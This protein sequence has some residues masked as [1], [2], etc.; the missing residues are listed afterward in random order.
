MENDKPAI[1]RIKELEEEV[2]KLRNENSRLQ[3][4]LKDHGIHYSLEDSNEDYDSEQGKRIHSYTVDSSMANRFFYMFWG[5]MDVYSQRIVNKKGKVGYYPQCW[6]FW[7]QGCSK[8]SENQNENKKKRGSVC[9]D[10]TLQ[11]WKKVDLGVLE[12]HLNGQI[13]MGIYP[14]LADNTCRLLVFDFDNHSEGSVQQDFANQDE[15]WKHEVDAVRTVCIENHIDPLVERSRSGKGAHIW[16]FFEKPVPASLARDFGECLLNKGAESFPLK[17]F[18]Y[19]DRMVP[20]QDRIRKGGLGNLIALPLQPD[21]LKE[22]NSAFVDENWNAYPDQWAVL[23][24]KPKLKEKDVQSFIQKCTDTDPFIAKDTNSDTTIHNAEKPWKLTMDFH[25]SDVQGTV[26]IAESNLIYIDT[27][28]LK[29]RIQNQIRRLAAFSNPKFW[30]NQAMNLSNFSVSR[31]VY[32]GEDIDGYIAI[33]RGLL[34]PLEAN[35]K[36]AGIPYTIEDARQNGKHIQIIFKGALKQNQQEAVDKM[37][38]YDDGILDAATSF[39][40]TVVCCNM[41]AV[42]KVNTL[43]LLESASLIPQWLEQ[44]NRFL[45]IDEELPTYQTKTGRVKTRSSRIGMLQGP[46]NTTTGIIDIAMVGSVFGKHGF[47]Q[48][49]QNYGMIIIDECHHAASETMQKVLREVKAKYVYGVTA[50]PVREDGLQKINYML[51]GP[52]RHRFSAK[53]RAK[54]QGINHLVYPRFTRCVNP[55][56]ERIEINEA[57]ELIMDDKVRNEQ[58]VDDTKTCIDEGRCP[59]ILTKYIKHAKVLYEKLNGYAK[60]TLLLL[61]E[62]PAK[63]KKET[64]IKMNAIPA[65]ESVLLIATGKLI[66]EG[67]DYPRLDTLIMAAPVAGESVVTQYAGRLNRDYETKK[68]VIVYDYIDAHIPVF[69]RMYVKRLKAYKHIGYQIYQ[70]RQSIQM[71][72][73]GFIFDVRNYR[74]SY[75]NDLKQAKKEIVICS[76]GLRA[77]KIS[78]MINLLKNQQENGVRVTVLTWQQ[79]IDNFE[80]GNARDILIDDLIRAGFDLRLLDDISEHFTIIDKE[81]VWYG[82]LNFLGKEDV[83]DNL[84]R[85][86]SPQIAEEL[87]E[88]A[89]TAKEDQFEQ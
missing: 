51:I 62:L 47:Q 15:E 70:S 11:S 36:A 12:K 60:H 50:T 27:R 77:R 76:P 66:G 10:C 4:L 46:K 18:K 54:E 55:R 39:G 16:I 57:Y 2:S 24:T 80:G 28:N 31:Y 44:L 45:E 58:I 52:I 30:K 21:A 29:P 38:T 79:D 61:G 63:Q 33:P 68:D 40:K 17:S 48:K 3:Q 64:F 65:C 20:G 73:P 69:D 37:L 83:D 82:S 88:I 25:A 19:Y 81:I 7:K 78:E 42:R 84:M 56:G 89:C 1:A 13:V 9:L 53:D 5:R 59:V 8:N 67:F 35:L 71:S 85:V 75:F 26:H 72:N 74:D 86:D 32:L 43:I 41:I 14:M 34:E 22:G 49:L 23:Q 6:N 87:L